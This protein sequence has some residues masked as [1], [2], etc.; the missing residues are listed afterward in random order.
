MLLTRAT[1][2]IVVAVVT[3]AAVTAVAASPLPT[4]NDLKPFPHAWRANVTAELLDA[5]GLNFTAAEYVFDA[6]HIR[7]FCRW[8]APAAQP[9]EQ[10]D[11][12]Q[13]YKYQVSYQ[14][15]RDD[16]D[17]CRCRPI[18]LTPLT[19]Q[20]APQ[21]F[22]TLVDKLARA[23]HDDRTCV[24]YTASANKRA[25]LC[26]KWHAD[27]AGTVAEPVYMDVPMDTNNELG[28]L[29]FTGRRINVVAGT[30]RWGP[31]DAAATCEKYMA[32]HHCKCPELNNEDPC[33]GV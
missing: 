23:P 18:S 7:T 31:F 16:V 11:A 24:L 20:F 17:G 33:G 15:R 5:I 26:L 1:V 19:N 9:D 30:F 13:W 29:W 14:Y 28:V 32:R 3:A 4:P 22:D 27:A 21:L 25:R 6:P 8:T 2:R 10:W 12:L